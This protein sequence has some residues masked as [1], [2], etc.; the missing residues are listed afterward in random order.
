MGFIDVIKGIGSSLS[1]VLG[2]DARFRVESSD[3]G[4]LV[5]ELVK[6]GVSKSDATEVIK[7]YRDM[8]KREKK[9]SNLEDSAINLDSDDVGYKPTDSTTPET[10]KSTSFRDDSTMKMVR[11]TEVK[12]V[13]AQELPNQERKPGGIE[14]D[15]RLK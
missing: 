3:E 11:N 14:R 7:Q 4:V 8:V 15:S 9:Y 1:K 6:S 10:E 13:S 12:S 5:T 2:D